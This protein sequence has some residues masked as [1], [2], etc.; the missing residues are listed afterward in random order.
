M[1]CVDTCEY[2]LTAYYENKIMLSPNSFYMFTFDDNET[3]QVFHYK[4]NS[5]LV[6][7]DKFEIYALSGNNQDLKMSVHFVCKKKNTK[8]KKL[9]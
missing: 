9:M 5:S 7:S 8:F 3:S 2:T 6:H 1:K 4:H